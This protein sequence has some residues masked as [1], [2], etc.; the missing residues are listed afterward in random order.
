MKGVKRE[1]PATGERNINVKCQFLDEANVNAKLRGNESKEFD[2]TLKTPGNIS[3][4]GST[5]SLKIMESF[6]VEECDIKIKRELLEEAR[7]ENELQEP[8]ETIN[9]TSLLQRSPGK[10]FE[11]CSP[12]NRIDVNPD[13]SLPEDCGD[14]GNPELMEETCDENELYDSNE[15]SKAPEAMLL[16]NPLNNSENASFP[17]REIIRENREPSSTSDCDIQLKCAPLEESNVKECK[18]RHISER[19]NRA[20]S[21][22]GLEQESS[23]SEDSGIQ[24]KHDLLENT[25][26]NKVLRQHENCKSFDAMTLQNRSHFSECDCRVPSKTITVKCELRSS[27]DCDIQVKR[28]HLQEAIAVK[29]ESSLEEFCG[30]QVKR[31]PLEEPKVDAKVQEDCAKAVVNDQRRVSESDYLHDEAKNTSHDVIFLNEKFA[32]EYEDEKDR[33]SIDDVMKENETCSPV[34]VE[35]PFATSRSLKR[36]RNDI[37]K[38]V[39][40][41]HNFKILWRYGEQ[42]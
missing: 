31:E 8:K 12:A 17:S 11:N 18:E 20:S 35:N 41:T 37:V 40:S 23:L 24:L 36:L 5:S 1:L 6:T 38:K 32:A 2:E 10:I 4:S 25:E 21:K 15:G 9:E 42:M 19:G 22:T 3:E 39:N 16:K 7:V 34:L 13:F 33:Q 14:K 30:I 28:E 27:G 29:R 26:L